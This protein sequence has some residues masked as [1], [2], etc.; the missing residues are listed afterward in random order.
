MW[1]DAN[2]EGQDGPT[3]VFPGATDEDARDWATTQLELDGLDEDENLPFALGRAT[4]GTRSTPR[5]LA[6]C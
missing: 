3:G 1:S 6:Q 2:L 4:S 5:L